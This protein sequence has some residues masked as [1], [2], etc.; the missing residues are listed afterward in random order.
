MAE[1]RQRREQALDDHAHIGARIGGG[2][3]AKLCAAI[4]ALAIALE[5]SSPNSS[6]WRGSMSNSRDLALRVAL[7]RLME[8]EI[9]AIAEPQ[10]LERAALREIA[11][12]L[13]RHAHA[14]MLHDLLGAAHMRR[15]LGDGLDDEMQVADRDALGQQQLEHAWRPG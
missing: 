12:D 5:A 1:H 14:H 10:H 9:P 11:A 2:D 7:E 4:D 3:E 13:L 6:S 8:G 15:D